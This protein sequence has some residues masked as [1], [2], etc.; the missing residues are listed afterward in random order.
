MLIDFGA[1]RQAVGRHTGSMTAVLKPG[2][3]PIE[4]YSAR[5]RQGP[6]TDIYA[7]GALAYW[8]LSG[9]VPV[10]ATER[11]E[12]DP[13]R[14]VAEVTRGRVSARLASAVDAA[15]A[16]KRASRPQSLEEWRGLLE[17]PAGRATGTGS[18]G[19]GRT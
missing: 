16:M 18:F 4:Q 15:L 3:A 1:A 12:E 8:A 2:Y 5:G 10:E 9:E 11:V 19:R 13:L 6:W 7:L 14:P 17:G